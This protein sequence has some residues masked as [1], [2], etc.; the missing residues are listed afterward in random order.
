[1]RKLCIKFTQRSRPVQKA[2]CLD[3]ALYVGISTQLEVPYASMYE[4][5]FQRWLLHAWAAAL[6]TWFNSD[7][8]HTSV[9][10]PLRVVWNMFAKREPTLPRT[11]ERDRETEMVIVLVSCQISDGLDPERGIRLD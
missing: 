9:L 5:Q 3:L 11:R 10:L 2:W 1:M 6:P 8:L 7:K 4:A